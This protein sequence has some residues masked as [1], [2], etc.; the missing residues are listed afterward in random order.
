M[1]SYKVSTPATWTAVAAVELGLCAYFLV[2]GH[3]LDLLAI[4]T[5]GLAPIVAFLIVQRPF[6]FPYGL[7]VFLIPFNG[8]L[9]LPGI[10]T[11]GRA[12]GVLSGGVLVLYALRKKKLVSP[13]AVVA[14]W[15]IYVMWALASIMWALDPEQ[16]VPGMS[17]LLQLFVLFAIVSITPS[18]RRDLITVLAAAVVSGIVAGAYGGWTFY[19][20]QSDAVARAQAQLGRVLLES[21][22]NYVDSNA[23]ADSLLF[24]L[25]VLTVLFLRERYKFRKAALAGAA[26]IVLAG[27]YF[28]AS[29]G[30]L[31]AYLAALIFMALASDYRRQ[32]AVF[33]GWVLA[34][35][36]A[37]P[38][39]WMR[40]A[41]AVDTGGS[42]RIS[43]WSTGL[44]AA[45]DH[46]LFGAGMNNFSRAYDAV[47][48]N[49]FQPYGAG[50][51]RAS[52]DILVQN[53]VELGLVGVI[54]LATALI[55]QYRVLSLIP[56][57]DSLYDYRLMLQASLI[58]L[59]VASIFIDMILAK[60]LW[61]VL[62][63]MVQ[64][65]AVRLGEQ[66]AANENETASERAAG[67]PLLALRTI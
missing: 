57:G 3:H 15:L 54:I 25:I 20:Q 22:E 10:G 46:W 23:Y 14:A 55:L 12:L 56:R 19:H 2:N 43:I 6:M 1:R 38:M 62:A 8:L 36:A 45:G 64:L 35:S 30:A 66:P 39:I 34:C 7:F 27:I 51:S 11:A 31:I 17:T 53:L 29:R 16:S 33:G 49:V 13:P 65:R 47:Y 67:A 63:T 44:K 40:F 5:L 32:L 60:Y 50:W 24:P 61:F 42:G 58:A 26:A 52:H 21:G 9:T 4:A 18:T 59:L 48:L 28:S 37:V 41:H